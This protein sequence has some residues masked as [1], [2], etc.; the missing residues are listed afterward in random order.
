MAC[1]VH[2]FACRW[3]GLLPVEF[4]DAATHEVHSIGVDLVDA[5]HLAAVVE[6]SGQ[7][8]HARVLS[9]QERARPGLDPVG[10]VS[11]LGT[12][13][14]MKESVVKALGGLPRGGAYTDITIG[15]PEGSRGHRPVLLTGRIG[16]YQDELGLEL[17]AS[18]EPLD[19]HLILSWAFAL[20]RRTR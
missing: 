13:F 2:E 19:E 20:A 16:A 8:F 1:D 12:Y 11:G 5:G 9:A 15:V 3:R 18:S 14:G 17:F 4:D 10:D 6:R 7:R